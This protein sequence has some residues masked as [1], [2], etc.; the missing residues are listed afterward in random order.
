MHPTDSES[1]PA[2]TA[3]GRRRS[4]AEHQIPI[5]G[6]RP[7][8]GG[9]QRFHFVYLLSQF[10]HCGE[11]PVA[12]RGGALPARRKRPCSRIRRAKRGGGALEVAL[13][14]LGECADGRESVE[15]A[16]LAAELGECINAFLGTLAARER[17]IFLRRYFF[18][19]TAE[20]IAQRCGMNA[21]GVNVVLH[22]T[23]KKLREH[24]QREGFTV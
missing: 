4:H 10:P 14:E 8:F 11:H 18:C 1:R 12:E 6:H 23:R 24:L 7:V 17:V 20:E 3:G 22:R 16:A 2:G 9:G 5:C 13:D 21:G 19:E 15:S